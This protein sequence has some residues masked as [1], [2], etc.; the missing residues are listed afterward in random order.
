[1][2]S[3]QKEI[4]ERRDKIFNTLLK[5]GEIQVK[6]LAL[7]LNVSELTVR[8]DLLFFEE[9]KYIER[10][11]G[12]ARLLNPHALHSPSQTL[13]RTKNKIAKKAADL[14][15]SG[16]IIF[17]NT[18]ST[19]LLTLRYLGNKEV[20]VITNNAKAV[21]VK[22]SPKVTIIL[23]G[24]LRNPKETMVG[25][26]A[27]KPYECQCL[28]SHL[29]CSG[30]SYEQGITTSVHSEVSINQLMLEN[31][32]DHESLSLIKANLDILLPLSGSI[33]DV[34]VLVTNHAS[35]AEA[36]EKFKEQTEMKIL[37]CN[38]F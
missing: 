26:F 8:R 17:I 22:T 19:A 12:G 16:D 27:Y 36:L 9:K 31:C 1:M 2:R 30:L 4:N 37:W 6:D 14:I 3:S 25:D 32:S 24:G 28:K 34:D 33:H 35:E 20:T 29:G 10:F 5:E 18:S 11:Y 21:F 23:S 13:N 7:K 15:D 38:T